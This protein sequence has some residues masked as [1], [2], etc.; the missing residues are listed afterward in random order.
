MYFVGLGIVLML[1]LFGVGKVRGAYRW[2]PIPG[3]GAFQPADLMRL[4]LVVFLAERL[5]HDKGA[6]TQFK[7]Y[8]RH[9]GVV[10]A[11]M[12]LIVLQPDLGTALAI[13]L[14]CALMMYV[15]GVGI[16][17]LA[18]FAIFHCLFELLLDQVGHLRQCAA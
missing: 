4:A 10:A 9:A 17:H 16:V 3:F 14:T 6:L 13:G 1:K 12:F 15:A 11:A 7:D 5:T 18:G 2:I 8:A